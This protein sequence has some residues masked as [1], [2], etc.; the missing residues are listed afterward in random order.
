MTMNYNI[1]VVETKPLMT[2]KKWDEEHQK[3]K[4][5]SGL[6]KTQVEWISHGNYSLCQPLDDMTLRE[7]KNSK[8]FPWVWIELETEYFDE[9]LK[10]I[11]EKPLPKT[12]EELFE[13]F[14]KAVLPPRGMHFY[15]TQLRA[16]FWGGRS[17]FV[18]HKQD[19]FPFFDGGPSPKISEMGFYKEDFKKIR[20][21][22]LN[23]TELPCCNIKF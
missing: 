21:M 13:P 8:F 1:G 19:N 3:Y 9:I 17:G 16:Y 18:I 7:D 10:A 2:R 12:A 23:T 11:E 6:I 14:W 22:A 5:D 15:E 20:D 4:D